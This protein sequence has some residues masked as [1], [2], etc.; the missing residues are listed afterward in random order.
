MLEPYQPASMPRQWVEKAWVHDMYH[1]RTG[2][3]A[4]SAHLF[5]S[6]AMASGRYCRWYE[7]Y[8]WPYTSR[9]MVGSKFSQP[10]APEVI[11][12]DF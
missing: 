7:F 1:D 10:G 3:G 12:F 2:P 5:G 6:H 4:T 11:E 8:C 9:Y